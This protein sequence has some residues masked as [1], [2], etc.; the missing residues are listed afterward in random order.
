[1]KNKVDVLIILSYVLIVSS[2]SLLLNDMRQFDMHQFKEFKVWAETAD[3]SQHW[4]NS[5]NAVKWSFYAINAA[6]FFMRGYLIY[7]FTYFISI[8][9]NIEKGHYFTEEN[10]SAFKKIG[11][12]FINY[13]IN[14][15]VLTFLL[16]TIK[17]QSFNFMNELKDGFTFLIPAGLAFYILA[18]VFNKAKETEEENELTI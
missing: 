4:F 8:L 13:S 14:V 6:L 11:T 3:K 12:I 5:K 7:S 17:E 18:E 9:K 2:V 1:M 16:A 15:F 10:I